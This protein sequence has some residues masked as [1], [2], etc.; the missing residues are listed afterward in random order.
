MSAIFLF[1]S[2]HVLFFSVC[3]GWLLHYL[4]WYFKFLVEL[5]LAGE[6]LHRGGEEILVSS[7][8]SPLLL[9]YD[10]FEWVGSLSNA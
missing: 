8:F 4:I 2:W 10:D 9:F 6:D 3:S 7:S 5:E 1:L